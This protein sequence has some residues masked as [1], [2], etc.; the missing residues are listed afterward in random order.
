MTKQPTTNRVIAFLKSVYRRRSQHRF[1]SQGTKQ[2]Q[3]GNFQID[4][5][6]DHLLVHILSK[7]PMRDQ[8]IGLVA[9]HISKKYPESTFLDIGA[10]VGD[11]AAIMATYAGNKL[12][13][14]EPSDYFF[15]FLK[16]NTAKFPNEITLVNTLVADGAPIAGELHHWSGT[17]SISAPFRQARTT[18]TKH[19]AEIATE[20]TR[21]IKIDTDGLDFKIIAASIDWLQISHPAILFEDQIRNATDLQSANEIFNSLTK[22]GYAFFTAWD[23]PGLH[24]LSTTSLTVIQDLNHYLFQLWNKDTRKAIHNYDILCLHETDADLFDA[25]SAQCRA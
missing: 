22:I 15:S 8:F 1:F 10:N 23:D 20:T 14:V 5:P 19:I 9:A 4:V 12:I 11:T 13:L 24:I 21:F 2:I 17:A 18:A 25:I 7:Q 3:C 16:R 6:E